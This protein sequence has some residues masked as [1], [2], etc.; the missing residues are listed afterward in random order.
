MALKIRRRRAEDSLKICNLACS[1]RRICDMPSADRH[2]SMIR[3]QVYNTVGDRH[4][5]ADLG[6]ALKKFRKGRSKLVHPEPIAG[7]DMQAAARRTAHSRDLGLRIINFG[8]IAT[9]SGKVDLTLRC[10]G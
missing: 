4:V 8:K 3:N 7:V 2:I 5:H 10:Q 6:I 1:Q 9:G